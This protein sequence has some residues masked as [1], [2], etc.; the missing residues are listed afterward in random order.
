M[1]SLTFLAFH[2]MLLAAVQA[3]PVPEPIQ[4]GDPSVEAATECN[5]VK[6]GLFAKESFCCPGAICSNNWYGT[7]AT[8]TKR[9]N[10]LGTTDWINKDPWWFWSHGTQISKPQDKGI[11]ADHIDGEGKSKVARA[12]IL[13]D[14]APACNALWTPCRRDAECCQNLLCRTAPKGWS[15]PGICVIDHNLIPPDDSDESFTRESNQETQNTHDKVT[16]SEFTSIKAPTCLGL[17]DV[18]YQTAGAEDCCAPLSCGYS[19]GAT[20]G[21]CRDPFARRGV[22]LSEKDERD[23]EVLD[24]E[25]TRAES[26]QVEE[27]PNCVR[28][29]GPCKTYECCNTLTCDTSRGP[30]GTCGFNFPKERTPIVDSAT[31]KVEES[32]KG[33]GDALDRAP[34]VKSPSCSGLGAAC[35]GSDCCEGLIC[36][37]TVQ[38][39]DDFAGPIGICRFFAKSFGGSV[40]ASIEKVAP[41]SNDNIDAASTKI[42]QKPEKR[43]I[44]KGLMLHNENE[45]SKDTKDETIQAIIPE[46]PR[47]EAQ[48]CAGVGVVCRQGDCCKF[49][50]C[51]ITDSSSQIGVCA[52]LEEDEEAVVKVLAAS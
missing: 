21:I 44:I 4:E 38:T 14:K 49:L 51:F 43:G 10:S 5:G 46:I 7:C 26:P 8:L 23:F 1:K 27:D 39:L 33:N 47:A 28:E 40:Q 41:D 32:Y 31:S 13:E 52:F 20:S 37:T 45:I 16:R 22:R 42:T 48:T 12:E 36:S 19:R 3:N 18:C 15:S 25:V 35:S 9:T 34:G 30:I 50:T 24:A 17:Y 6:C 29:G 2:V 11:E